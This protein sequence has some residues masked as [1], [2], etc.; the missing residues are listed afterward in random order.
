MVH[1][2]STEEAG[3]PSRV[4]AGRYRLGHPIGA[5]GMGE[6]WHAYDERLDRR[7]AVK[8]MLTDTR[9]LP[10]IPG[11]VA[12]EMMANRRDRFL[13]EVRTTAA[14][15]HLGIPAIY[16]TGIDETTHQLF[17]VMQ[18]L[19][20]REVQTFIDQ[21][22]YDYAPLG[23]SWAAAAG[24]QIASVLDEVHRNDVVHRDIK[25]ANVMISTD[26]VVK[27][28]DF[29]VAA[30]RGAGGHP[31]LTQEGMTIGTP[32]YMSPE[33]SLANQVGPASDIYALACVMYELLT[34]R[35]PFSADT[36]HSHAWHHVR[37]MPPPIRT[38]RPDVPTELETLLLG[39]LD[40][41]PERR[42]DASQ[43]YDALLPWVY[44]QD[45]DH[46]IRAEFDPRQPFRRP[47][48]GP[49]K[50]VSPVG[51][52]PTMVVPVE[53][54][55]AAQPSADELT[56][57]EADE[58]ADVA[59]QLAQ[60]G[61]L[62]QAADLLSTA[63]GRAEELLRDDLIFSLAQVRFLAGAYSEAAG[64]F[65]EAGTGYASRYGTEDDQALL[66]RYYTA[67]CRMS[68]GETTAAIDEFRAYVAKKPDTT[69]VEAVARYLDSLSAL[70]RL[71]AAGERFPEAV[72]A[73]EELRQATMSLR[74][75]SAP[76][77]ADIDGFLARL[78]RFT[79]E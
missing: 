69:N 65:E 25:P 23:I 55:V 29:G 52:T 68:L 26:G 11:L 2:A 13:R 31:R 47:F 60:D 64:H 56:E 9:G 34:G 51:Y 43:V 16:D 18:L 76:E 45:A 15:E 75:P 62:T 57:Q 39:M 22:D 58:V 49:P 41:E 79:D 63:I 42:L 21:T 6:V 40:K 78:R 19:R 10:G 50:R 28:L 35:P 61:K 27:V 46:S 12:V 44:Q 5:G 67:Q 24:V 77:L 74:G 3:R 8:M 32:P 33:Q 14:L 17:V 53:A 72:K 30:L 59:A 38:M 54:G 4:I 48:S 1:N 71:F 37:S 7:V 73:A 66:C 20:G 70:T 36:E